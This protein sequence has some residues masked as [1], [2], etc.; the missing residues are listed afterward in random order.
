MTKKTAQKKQSRSPFGTNTAKPKASRGRTTTEQT[1]FQLRA[2]DVELDPG[3]RV[4]IGKRVGFKLGRYGLELDR[5]AVRFERPSGPKG[6]PVFACQFSL[7]LAS[8]GKV[9]VE[10]HDAD[11]RAA[12]DTAIDGAERAVRRLLE[13]RQGA[14]KQS[15]RT[16]KR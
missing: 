6:A 16:A 7:T 8:A 11:A 12:F 2:R 5:V 9:I 15:S 13:K 14:S 10:A 1:P 3:M 4:Y